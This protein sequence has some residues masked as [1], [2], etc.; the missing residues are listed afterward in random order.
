MRRRGSATTTDGTDLALSEQ[1]AR[2]VAPEAPE[3]SEDVRVIGVS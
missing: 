1:S 2:S 3:A